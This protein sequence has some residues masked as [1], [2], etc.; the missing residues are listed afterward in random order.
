MSSL[1]KIHPELRVN[2]TYGFNP[3]ELFLVFGVNENEVFPSG[4]ETV[5]IVIHMGMKHGSSSPS[6]HPH[7]T[8]HKMVL[9]ATLQAGGQLKYHRC[10]EK[11][12]TTEWTHTD[13]LVYFRSD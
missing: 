13:K 2:E 8:L 12:K 1:N 10:H 11:N 6:T 5:E 4:Q 9:D 7:L 3:V